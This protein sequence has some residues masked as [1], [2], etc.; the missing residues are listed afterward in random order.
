MLSPKVSRR[1]G[2][3]MASPLLYDDFERRCRFQDGVIDAIR[4]GAREVDDLPQWV[5]DELVLFEASNKSA[6]EPAHS[7]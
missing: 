2:R 7:H 4:A 3:A 5:Q 1:L 6:Q